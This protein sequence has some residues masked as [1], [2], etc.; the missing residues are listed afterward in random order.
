MADD[1]GWMNVS[2]YGGDI[3][4]LER[5]LFMDTVYDPATGVILNGDF[6][7]TAVGT[8]S[9]MPEVETHAMEVGHAPGPY[10]LVGVGE[11]TANLLFAAVNSAVYNAIGQWIDEYPLTPDKVLAAVE[12]ALSGSLV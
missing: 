7:Y 1:V 5:G 11:S 6:I 8:M 4:G 3:M 9:E 12:K 2:S 10:G